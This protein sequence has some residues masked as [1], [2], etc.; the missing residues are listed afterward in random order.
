[1]EKLH[2]SR[3]GIPLE[4]WPP[5]ENRTFPADGGWNLVQAGRLI[6]KKAYDDSL[7]AFV[8]FKETFPAARF[9]I[10]GEGPLQGELASLAKELGVRDA[11]EFCGF[12]DQAGLRSVFENA[13]IFLHPSRTAADGNRE[14]VPNAMLEAMAT[15]LPVVATNHG[16]IPEAVDDGESGFLVPENEPGQLAESLLRVT[17]DAGLWKKFS[18]NAIAGVRGKF[19]REEQIAAL[20]AIYDSTIVA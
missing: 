11:V 10:V 14:G 12:L 8:E 5:A 2:L 7:R 18:E 19:R 9:Q 4:D 13:H 3:T 6:E 17:A 15:G 20:E 16:G 1:A